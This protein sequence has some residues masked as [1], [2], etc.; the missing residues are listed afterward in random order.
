MT[1][2]LRGWSESSGWDFRGPSRRSW[3]RP[4]ARS[5]PPRWPP[6][7]SRARRQPRPRPRRPRRPSAGA[8]APASFAGAV[9][10]GLELVA[11]PLAAP[12]LAAGAPGGALARRAVLAR[13]PEGTRSLS[14]LRDEVAGWGAR[15]DGRLR[16]CAVDAEQRPARGLRRARRAARPASPRRSRRPAR[17]PRCSGPSTIGGRTYVD[18]GAWS[19]TNLDV[20][21]AG[22]DAHVLCLTR[23]GRQRDPPLADGR[24]ARRGPPAVALEAAALRRR[25]ARVTRDRAR[26]AVLGGV[27]PGV[28]DPR[29]AGPALD[30]GHRQGLRARLGRRGG[31]SS[32]VGRVGRGGDLAD[33]VGERAHVGDRRR[34]EDVGRHALARWPSGPR[35]RGRRWSRRARPCRR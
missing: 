35:A 29:S 26:R 19:L 15:F 20:A 9:G 25:G 17:S 30:A 21:P 32:G 1:G 18:G 12:A 10:R 5:W 2:V 34:L 7:A 6:A 24:A 8:A 13:V 11:T 4:R 22:R 27:R 28:L 16:I 33:D 14:R 23:R 3:A 31:C